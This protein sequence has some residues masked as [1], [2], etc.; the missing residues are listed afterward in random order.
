MGRFSDLGLGV[1]DLGVGFGV[2]GFGF[3]ARSLRFDFEASHLVLG[4]R[5]WCLRSWNQVSGVSVLDSGFK[6]LEGQPLGC[7]A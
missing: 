4:F 3:G 7:L 5:R 6:G 1:S 2:W